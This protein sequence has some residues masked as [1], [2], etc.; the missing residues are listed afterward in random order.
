MPPGT[1]HF[2]LQQVDL[3]GSTTL[4]RPATVEVE[5]VRAI[6]FSEPSPNPV[7]TVATLSFAVNEPAEARVSVFNILGQ[8]LRTLFDGVPT[9]GVNQ[10]LRFDTNG[11]P[12]GIYFVQLEVDGQTRMHR[13]TVVR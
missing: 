8:R 1:H 11:L 4:S 2:R 9:P 12:N 10:T 5:L 3:D 6:R 13:I 7:S